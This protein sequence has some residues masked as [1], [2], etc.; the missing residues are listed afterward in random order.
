L[1]RISTCVLEHMSVDYGGQNGFAAFGTPTYNPF[2]GPA[3]GMPTE[4]NMSLKFR[5]L[6]TLTKE[7][8]NIGY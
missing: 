6:E 3:A 7:R 2:S 5:E 8:I 1:N 4:I